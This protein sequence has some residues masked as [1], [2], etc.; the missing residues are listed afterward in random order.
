MHPCQDISGNNSK[1]E[2]GS[3]ARCEASYVCIECQKSGSLHGHIQLFVQCLHQHTPLVEVLASMK[4]D[5]AD[6]T[7]KYLRYKQTVS[8]QE[9][10]DKDLA[11]KRLPDV[12]SSWPEYKA[13]KLL[14]SR[15]KYLTHRDSDN[16]NATASARVLSGK[17]WLFQFLG[18]HVQRLQEHKQHHV[19]LPNEQGVRM[20]LTHCKRVDD[21]KKCK[22]DFPR[23][24]WLVD[25]A[26]VLCKGLLHRMDM[27]SSGRRSKLG[28]LHGPMN[29]E[30]LNGTSPALLAAQQFNSDVQIPYRV[31]L[32]ADSH[33][34]Q[35][36]ELCL[37]EDDELTMVQS[38]QFGQDAQAGYACDYCS[39]R[40][41]MAFNEI[42]ECCKGHQ[43]LNEKLQGEARN[44][45]GKR[46]ATRLM[47]D[48]YGKGIVRGQCEC[49]HLRAYSKTSDVLHAE[50]F[51]TSQTE[52]FHGREYFDIVERLNDKKVI[53]SKAVFAEVDGRNPRRRKVTI[54][55]VATLYGQRPRHPDVWYLSPYEFVMYWS[56]EL[57]SV[58]LSLGDENNPEHH[59]KLSDSGV[60]KLI[61]KC[62]EL[63]PGKDYH[64]KEGGTNWIAFPDSPAASSFRH[65]W[66]LVRR[67]RPRTPIFIGSPIPRHSH[68]EQQRAAAI[69]MSYFHPW[70]L[71]LADEEEHVRFA[72]HLRT[73]EQTWQDALQ[74]WLNGSI[75]C[76][77]SKQ[78]IGNFL[79]VHRMRPGDEEEDMCNSD[80]IV[81]DEELELSR[82]SLTAALETKV[83]GKEGEPPA[84]DDHTSGPTHFQNSHSAIERNQEMWSAQLENE[85]AVVSTFIEPQALQDVLGAAKASQRR[86]HKFGSAATRAHENPTLRELV[87]ATAQNVEIWLTKKKIELNE[88]GSLVVNAEQFS[89]LEKVAKRVMQELRQAANGDID[90]GEPLRWLIH[91]GPGTGKSHVIKQVK[92]LFSQ[93]LHWE[94]GVEY[95]VVALQAVMADQLGGDTIHHA[96]G[97]PVYNK[98]EGETP[99]KQFEIAKRVLQWR[100]LIIDEISMVSAKL[101]ATVDVKLRSTVRQI[102]TQKVGED[103]RDR[104]F[105]GLNV[106]LCGDFWQL[107]P[108]DGG[109]LG[110]IPTQFIQKARKYQ[111]APTIAHGQALMWG[112]PEQGVQGVTELVQCERC[113]DQWLREVQQEL[114]EGSLSKN[115]HK[116]LHGLP[117]SVPGSWLNGDVSCGNNACR[118]LYTAYQDEPLHSFARS[119]SAKKMKW[120][121]DPA[122]VLANE[123]EQCKK[124]RASRC[125]VAQS[126]DDF[127][128]EKFLTAPAI[129]ANN[130]VKY[131]T[132]K[133]RAQKY[134]NDKNMAVTFAPAKDTPSH[135]AMRER[136]GIA[137]EKINWLQWHDRDTGNLYGVLPLVHG[138]P[139]ALTDHVN[140]NPDKQLLRGKIGYVHSWVVQGEETSGFHNGVRILGKV[141]KT[142]FIKYRDCDCI[143]PKACTR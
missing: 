83:G 132:N 16:E 12:E 46:H 109:F 122:H 4:S 135:D 126:Q 62:I 72:G 84:T 49:T 116:F 139:M 112:G 97:I 74:T 125:R 34:K 17:N 54:R 32:T 69:V 91:G 13:S 87:G 102:G 29:H 48:A 105:G 58:P 115:N 28:S 52:S 2:G 42:K 1:F 20:P 107:A 60:Q 95:Q 35:C 101:L 130:D 140:R 18:C 90:F 64:V 14:I 88:D 143:L 56:P 59:V 67:S 75:L 110:D 10:Y 141:P 142:V 43:D 25:S 9:Y 7:A 77:E 51:R 5:G 40:Q 21:P 63:L 41:P 79:A 133:N 11:E 103:N 89:A 134:A 38:F 24:K 123:C 45:V 22:A 44:Y 113:K 71:R 114:R 50:T 120:S 30:S 127:N 37:Q 3:F 92:L 108:P 23:T 81:S 137:A 96:C 94:M 70:T 47:S 6:I 128:E 15:P 111:P 39:K 129:F 68:G 124:D 61:E 136:P 82:A 80:D 26:V 106:L 104:P 19:H 85:K 73:P 121:T 93:V 118:L 76:L 65:T 131:A 57:A 86:E 100:W 117:T 138:M 27:A 78:F 99:S 31:P 119:R 53:G 66:I 33:S 98:G 8:R 36:C 55:D